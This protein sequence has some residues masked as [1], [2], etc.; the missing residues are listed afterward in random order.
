MT[1]QEML[2]EIKRSLKE[3]E[4]VDGHWKASEL[5]RRANLAQSDICKKTFC[6]KK[7]EVLAFDED[8]KKYIRPKNCYKVKQVL[9][10]GRRLKGTS[11]EEADMLAFQG[12][13]PTHW[14]EGEH[15]P[16]FYILDYRH[17]RLCPN[18]IDTSEKVEIEYY[19]IAD[20]M[21]DTSDNPFDSID[22][23]QEWSQLIIDY[24]L[25]KCLLEDK[26]DRYVEFKSEYVSGLRDMQ[27]MF[28]QEDSFESFGMQRQANNRTF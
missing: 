22:Y 26:D 18:N 17:I 10:D 9:F 20:N 16:L 27:K 3:P 24:V 21:V 1:W 4:N 12:K 6:I 23:L 14:R 13:F 2:I 5:L 28:S 7:E 15:F 25:W 11:E 19:S 8:A